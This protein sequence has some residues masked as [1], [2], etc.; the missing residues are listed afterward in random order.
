MT[1][2]ATTSCRPPDDKRPSLFSEWV[3]IQ[4]SGFFD[5]KKNGYAFKNTAVRDRSQARDLYRRHDMTPI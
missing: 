4:V 5:A 2:N 1:N 3:R